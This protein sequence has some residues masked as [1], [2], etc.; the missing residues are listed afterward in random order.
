MTRKTSTITSMFNNQQN[1]MPRN[2]KNVEITAANS[3]KIL[4]YSETEKNFQE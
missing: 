1:R 3:R 2:Q 4:H